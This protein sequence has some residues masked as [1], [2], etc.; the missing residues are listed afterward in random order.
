MVMV[1]VPQP[2]ELLMMLL[3]LVIVSPRELDSHTVGAEAL[4]VKRLQ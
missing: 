1:E 3:T 2:A 4:Q